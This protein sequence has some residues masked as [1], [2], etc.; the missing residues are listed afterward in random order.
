MKA[1]SS[2]VE[3]EGEAREHKRRRDAIEILLEARER[4]FAQLTEDILSNREV[5]LDSSGPDGVFSFEFQEI[6]NRYSG[7]IHALNSLLESLEYRRP[8][9]A[10]KV[11]TFIAS[12]ESLE[13]DINDV[14]SSH[15]QWDLVD[16][17]LTPLEDDKF[18]VVAAF[19]VDEYVE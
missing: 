15:D 3:R 6:D 7:R 5:I 19:T 9:F 1:E 12:R 13:K 14:V 17:N 11:E 10:H 8:R 2:D 16:M 4:L 18:L